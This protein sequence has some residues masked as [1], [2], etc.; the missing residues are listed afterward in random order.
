[1][2]QE[3]TVLD[4]TILIGKPVIR[5]TRLAVEFLIDLMA[6]GWTA[7]QILD[8]YPP[9]TT[10]DLKAALHYAADARVLRLVLNP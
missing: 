2:W 7:S 3:R 4:P 5:G 8:N 10:D 9:L 6:E 1:M